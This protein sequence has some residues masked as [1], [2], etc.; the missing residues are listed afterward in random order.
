MRIL[1]IHQNRSSLS[2]QS[3]KKPATV[4]CSLLLLLSMLAFIA[5]VPAQ[6]ATITQT[7]GN[8]SVGTMTNCFQTDRDATRFQLTQSGT[9][10]SITAYF[11]STGF[12]AKAAIYTDS[13]GA[14]SQLVVQSDAQAVTTKGWNTFQLDQTSL[15]TGYYWLCV[16]SSSKS[17]TGL[18]SVSSTN[19]HAWK[20]ATYSN[21]YPSYFGTPS[22]YE[23][24]STSIYATYT[25]TTTTPTPTPTPTP[26]ITPTPTPTTTIPPSTTDLLLGLGH[27]SWAYDRNSNPVDIRGLVNLAAASGANCWRE[28]MAVNSPVTSYQLNLKSY[29]DAAG[30]KLVIQTLASSAGAMSVQDELNIINNVG[31]AQSDWI[32][33]WGSKIAKLQPYGIMI[34]NE[35]SNGGTYKTA[36]SS[37]FAAYRQF[38]INAINAWRQIDPDLVIIVNNYPFN[39]V[40]DS[41]SYGFAANPLPFSNILYGRHIYYVYDNSYPPSYLPDQRAYWTGNLVQGKQLLADLL[42]RESSALI[43]K[44]QKVIWD[45]WGANVNAPNAKAYVQDFISI[46]R[47]KGIGCLYYDLVPSTYSP[48]GILNADYK[49]LNSVGQAWANSL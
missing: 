33:S 41:T 13:N 19:S 45:E 46:C 17:S 18:M 24:S 27:P 8:T 42:E 6:G 11:A 49:T 29:L 30:V 38:C 35:P 12:N 7:F 44:G 3:I 20:T 32:N 23:K 22:G 14:P 43:A 26:T 34:M 37:A 9:V 5:T 31:T 47:S 16:V 4:F 21:D 36:S 25:I 1:N 48:S 2:L 28:A 15:S 10:Q 40:F 39:D